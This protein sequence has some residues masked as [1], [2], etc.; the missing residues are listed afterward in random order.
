MTLDL[1]SLAKMKAAKSH[2]CII[3]RAGH[4]IPPNNCTQAMKSH[5]GTKEIA[6]EVSTQS[7]FSEYLKDELSTTVKAA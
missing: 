6:T 1:A 4:E 5:A 3:D 7:N 2:I